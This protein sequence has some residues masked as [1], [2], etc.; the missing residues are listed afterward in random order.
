MNSF[1]ILSA[2]LFVPLLGAAGAA[3]L[4]RVAGWSWA[5]VAALAVLVRGVGDAVRRAPVV[6][7]RSRRELC[8]WRGRHQPLPARLECAVDAR[9]S[10]RVARC[11]TERRPLARVLLPADAAQHGHAGCLP[12]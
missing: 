6:A 2:I 1:P 5:F 8:P 7:A 10:G 3:V 9:R 12:R 4:P 11:G